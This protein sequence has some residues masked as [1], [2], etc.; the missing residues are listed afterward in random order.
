MDGGGRETG[1]V[2]LGGHEQDA[3]HLR[4]EER[5]HGDGCGKQRGFLGG[6]HCGFRGGFRG[7]FH[8][9]FLVDFRVDLPRSF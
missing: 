2:G 8:C 5:G 4:N 7:G 3:Q 6:F 1:V 9:G